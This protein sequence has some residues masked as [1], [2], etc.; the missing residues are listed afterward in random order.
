MQLFPLSLAALV[1][2]AGPA[3]AEDL[4][5]TV[6][7][8]M[9][10]SGHPIHPPKDEPADSWTP[11]R[12]WNGKAARYNDATQRLAFDSFD[13]NRL[14]G[15]QPRWALD[16]GDSSRKSA[17]PYSAIVTTAATAANDPGARKKSKMV[18]I[19]LPDGS[20]GVCLGCKTL[21]DGVDGVVIASA[22]SANGTP[23]FRRETG[24]K[25]YDVQNKDNVSWYPNGDWLTVAVELPVHA[26][27]HNVATG[28]IG[29]FTD[30]WAIYVK[31]DDPSFGKIWVQLTDWAR[32]WRESGFYDN[33]A[34]IPYDASEKLCPAGTQYAHNPTEVP[35]AYYH[36]SG[37]GAPPPISGVMR[38]TI[39]HS[40]LPDGNAFI[41]WGS[42]VGVNAKPLISGGPILLST[43]EIKLA[44]AGIKGVNV[45]LPTFVNVKGPFGPTRAHPD[46]VDTYKGKLYP[47]KLDAV[48][49]LYEAWDVSADNRRVLIAG[50]VFLSGNPGPAMISPRTFSFM[51]VFEYAI[52]GSGLKDLTAY[53]PAIGYGYPPSLAPRPFNTWG[54]WEEASVYVTWKGR[55]YVAFCSNA[56]QRKLDMSRKTFGLDT[57]LLDLDHPK[58]KQ[59]TVANAPDAEESKSLLYPNGWNARDGILYLSDVPV[60]ASDRTGNDITPPA[61]QRAMKLGAALDAGLM[62]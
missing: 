12:P 16:H 55:H 20:D 29:S 37:T 49:Q 15:S 24:A 58:A 38:P 18:Y 46:G 14:V 51:D 50:D 31:P 43:A 19:T 21:V 36:C 6:I 40:L 30:I 28:G 57:W 44:S 7:V 53:N 42:R 8:G 52:D 22:P 3:A 45:K 9:D 62:N 61:T 60:R 47:G 39:S 25:I 5:T 32:N 48:G 10:S 17:N 13:G 56:G 54:Y 4:P 59:I 35:F 27:T 2:L 1:F 33:V 11:A 34:M 26:G 41:A 23:R